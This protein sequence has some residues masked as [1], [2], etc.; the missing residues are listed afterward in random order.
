MLVQSIVGHRHLDHLANRIM[1]PYWFFKWVAWK[2]YTPDADVYDC[3]LF[4]VMWLFLWIIDLLDNVPDFWKF[5][6]R[7]LSFGPPLRYLSRCRKC[8]FYGI[9]IS[10]SVNVHTKICHEPF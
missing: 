3:Y 8:H 6:S 7:L 10:D 2:I 9:V 1:V 4:D 5:L